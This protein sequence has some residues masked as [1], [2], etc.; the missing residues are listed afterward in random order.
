M[1]TAW[2]IAKKNHAANGFDGEGARL[3]GS[4]WSTPGTRVAFASESLS[5]ATLEIVV[6]LQ[7]SAPLA[8]Y[9]V[10][11]VRFPED[12]V[13]ELDPSVLP[14]N[15]RSFPAPPRVRQI[16]DDWVKSNSSVLLRVPSVIVVHE[17]NFLIN[18]EHSDFSKLI[19]S[20][21]EPLDIDPGVLGAGR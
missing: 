12:M 1:P 19:I 20:G 21:P 10:F 3:Y 18:P 6:H 8:S 17:H 4:R 7:N 16:G 9:V 2:R 13:Q 11:T 5:L 15:W 14:K